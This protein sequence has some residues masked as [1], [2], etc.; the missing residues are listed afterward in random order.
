MDTVP[1]IDA[2]GLAQALSAER[3]P[4]LL[5]VRPLEDYVAGH[6]PGARHCPVHE[7]S[8]RPQE[9][10]RSKVARVLVF[11]EPGKRGEAAVRFLHLIGY[12]DVA[13]VEGGVAAYRGDLEKGPPPPPPRSGPELRI[14]P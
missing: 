10:P 12:A 7:L 3:P 14:V 13:L 4:F 11:A 9:L 8:K 6:V 1:R 2:E 5:D